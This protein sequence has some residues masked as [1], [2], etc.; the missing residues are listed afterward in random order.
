M[1]YNQTMY[2]V[3]TVPTMQTTVI[4]FYVYS[5]YIYAVF[6]YT[7][8]TFCT[9][10]IYRESLLLLEYATGVVGTYSTF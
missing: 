4:S 1:Y 5:S 3:S 9:L 6:A 10:E 2:Y 8:S 7:Y